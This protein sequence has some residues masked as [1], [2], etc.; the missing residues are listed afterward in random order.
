MLA[1]ARSRDHSTGDYAMPSTLWY[2]EKKSWL[3]QHW[4]CLLQE[5]LVTKML[6]LVDTL[7]GMFRFSG[8][9]SLLGQKAAHRP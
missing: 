6:L 2:Q 4:S 3:H 1:Q 8:W 7:A 5:H 9:Y